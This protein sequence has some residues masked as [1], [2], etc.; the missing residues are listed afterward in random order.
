M[1][2]QLGTPSVRTMETWQI[3]FCLGS[4]TLFQ[5]DNIPHG[6]YIMTILWL[7]HAEPCIY[8]Q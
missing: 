7:N 4:E 2:I 1:E 6:E 3:R 8:Y 5:L